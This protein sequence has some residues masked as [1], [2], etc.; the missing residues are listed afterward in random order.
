[1][2]RQIAQASLAQT[3]A[4]GQSRD[5][6]FGGGHLYEVF[7]QPI[8]FGAAQE[9]VLLGVLATGFEIDER[10]AAVVAQISSS[11]VAFCYGKTV[12]ISTLLPNQQT[13][14]AAG[15]NLFAGGPSLKTVEVRLGDENFV[16]TS[17]E[18]A[19]T[20]SEPVTLTVLK[21]YDQATLFLQDLNR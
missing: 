11:R 9:N 1:F 12:V 21:S 15:Q 19:P 17:V 13:E 10:L 4:R 5:W 6:W 20:A 18:L 14:L 3:L 16:G 2:D 7:L 8:Y